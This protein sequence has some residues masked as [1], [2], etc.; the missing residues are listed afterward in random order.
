MDTVHWQS[1][2]LPCKHFFG[3]FQ[4]KEDWTWDKLPTV[5]LKLQYL[6]LDV[7]AITD[8][9]SSS[10]GGPGTEFTPAGASPS[11]AVTPSSEK[12]GEIQ[13]VESDFDKLPTNVHVHV[14]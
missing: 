1:F 7:S 10:N 11:P 8:Y 6:S 4:N 13:P 3:V 12:C 2:H 5:Y 14:T 9:L